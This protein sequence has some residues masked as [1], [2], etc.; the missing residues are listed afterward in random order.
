MLVVQGSPPA[1]LWVVS[2]VSR[3]RRRQSV[4]AY[5]Y[6]G[7]AYSNEPEQCAFEHLS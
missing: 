1:R 4:I 3:C 2:T 6:S 7:L 5:G